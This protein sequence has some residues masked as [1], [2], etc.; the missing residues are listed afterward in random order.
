MIDRKVLWGSGDGLAWKVIG[1][2]MLTHRR[3]REP[4][5]RWFD[6]DPGREPLEWELLRALARPCDPEI[7]R[8]KVF[9]QRVTEGPP[10]FGGSP[11]VL[12]RAL[13]GTAFPRITSP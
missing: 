11:D 7:K 10:A 9:G 6:M 1:V 3:T 4:G 12:L 13:A 5:N 2:T 8:Y